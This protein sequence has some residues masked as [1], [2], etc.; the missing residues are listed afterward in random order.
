MGGELRKA[1]QWWSLWKLVEATILAA[2]AA[3]DGDGDSDSDDKRFDV[4]FLYL[5]PSSVLRSCRSTSRLRHRRWYSSCIGTSSI[6]SAGCDRSICRI[7]LGSTSFVSSDRPAIFLLSLLLIFQLHYN[8]CLLLLRPGLCFCSLHNSS[9]DDVDDSSHVSAPVV[10]LDPLDRPVGS[11]SPLVVLGRPVVTSFLSLGCY[12]TS[13]LS[14]FSMVF[15]FCS[16]IFLDMLTSSIAMNFEALFIISTYEVGGFLVM[17]RRNSSFQTFS[18]NSFDPC[19]FSLLLNLYGIWSTKVD[20]PRWAPIGE[21]FTKWGA[22]GHKL[23]RELVGSK[24]VWNPCW[25]AVYIRVPEEA[26]VA[27]IEVTMDVLGA[28]SYRVY[29]VIGRRTVFSGSVQCNRV[30]YSVM[31][32]WVLL[33]EMGGGRTTVLW[34]CD[35]TSEGRPSS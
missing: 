31:W 20:T 8:S 6:S 30:V 15:F 13:T 1:K 22:S 33:D 21:S 23:T 34:Y 5:S 4:L 24:V 16:V 26:Y 2:T 19:S 3:S 32:V 27:V 14:T 25:L 17:E 18:S 35:G 7:S 29:S 9:R 10:G 28:A 12:S 11:F